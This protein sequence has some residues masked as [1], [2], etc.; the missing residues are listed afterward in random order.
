MS[1]AKVYFPLPATLDDLEVNLR[2]EVANLDPDMLTRALGTYKP[3]LVFA[4]QT[5]AATLK[6]RGGSAE[7]GTLDACL[8][9][10]GGG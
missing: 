3:E 5:M 2:R 10:C 4:W 7:K 6:R 1:S 8:L 9:Y